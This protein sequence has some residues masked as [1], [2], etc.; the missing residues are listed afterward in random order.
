MRTSDLI[1]LENEMLAKW[2][3]LEI[4]KKLNEKNKDGKVFFFLEGPPYTNG[5]LHMGH[6]R[7]YT[8][9]DAILRYRRMKGESVFDRAGFDVHGLPIENK[10][11]KELG[12]KN[13]KEI[14]ASIGVQ[15]FVNSCIKLYKEYLAIQIDMAKKYGIWF[16]FDNAYIPATAQYMDKSWEVFKKIYEKKLVYKAIQ[17]MPY[18]IHCGTVLAK[19]P[20]VEEK[21]DTDPSIYVA[22]RINKELS[23]PKIKIEGDVSLLM[24]TT[25]P[26]TLP[27]NIVV[28]IN[29]KIR[30]VNVEIEG[31][32]YILA[33]ARLDAVAAEFGFSPIVIDEFDGSQLEGLYYVHPLEDAIPKQKVM[34]KQHRTVFSEEMVSQTEGTGVVHISPAFGPEDFELARKEKIPMISAVSLDGIYNKDAGKY[35]G[36]PLIHEANRKIEEEL[37][38]AGALLGKGSLRHN[39]PH[40]WRCKEKLVFLPTEQWFVKVAKIKPKIRKEIEKVQWHPAEVK[41]WFA[42]GIETAPDWAISRQRYWGIPIPLWICDSCGERTVIGSFEELKSKSGSNIE[43]VAE[44]M[45][46]PVIDGIKI[47]CPKCSSKASRIP[48][49][50]D[51]WY[52]SGVAHTA[53]LSKEEFDVMFSKAFITEGP[54]QLRGWFA[55]LMKTSVAAYGKRSFSTLA[56]Q[57]WVVDER[58]DAMH[59]SKGNYVAAADIIGKNSIDA[60]RAFTLSHVTQDALKFSNREIQE[61]ESTLVMLHNISSLINEYSAAIGYLGIKVK[62]PSKSSLSSPED[63]WILSRLNT[64]IGNVTGGFEN[65]E[66]WKSVNELSAFL[67]NDLSRFYLKLAKKKILGEDT[68]KAKRELDIIN[69]I[70]YNL[71]LAFA[72]IAPMNSDYIYTKNYKEQQSVFF[73]KW[74]KQNKK[75]VDSVLES[76]FEVAGSVITSLLN[77]REKSGVKLRWPIQ[78]AYVQLSSEFAFNSVKKLSDII[79]DYVNSKE[80][81]VTRIEGVSRQVK[82]AFQKLGPD[83]KANAG[84][85]AEALKKVDADKLILEVEKS[86]FYNLQTPKG[87]FKITKDHFSIS[88]KSEK[89]DAISFKYGIAYV[90]KE[91]SKELL[92]E[93]MVREFERRIQLARK[94]AGLRKEDKVIIYYKVSPELAE[95]VG[96]N[97]DLI[98]RDVGASVIEKSESVNADFVKEFDLDEERITIGIK[99]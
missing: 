69:Y 73:E 88:E 53:S 12:I 13:K 29:P 77:S 50:F 67:I 3:T 48:D 75:M 64:V 26:W 37:K 7:G 18:C 82:P 45:H 96:R 42:E 98:K 21:E 95:I 5:E 60:V 81:V 66:T 83:F 99:K 20:E 46:R 9:K 17:V 57:G 23:K 4:R 39:Y 1:N 47:N 70:M 51:V 24:W 27:G 16:D 36:I 97:S 11:E 90:D 31:R 40:C 25:T 65:Y 14:E 61:M 72:P 54:D 78:K 76:E 33:K 49:I 19:G 94:E 62:K 38:A 8:R 71:L 63:R 59:K 56:L 34:R 80:L 89:E 55:T 41:D 28:A 85:V 74:P 93:A 79:K 2:D 32:R 10:V 84:A 87:S 30:Y 92:D 15:N 68:R 58:G 44:N 43:Y 35:E 52:D 91:M 6:I 22:Y 86:G